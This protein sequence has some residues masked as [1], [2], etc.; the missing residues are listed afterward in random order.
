F[1]LF[2]LYGQ[3]VLRHHVGIL[4]TETL[5]TTRGACKELVNTTHERS[6]QRAGRSRSVAGLCFIVSASKLRKPGVSRCTVRDAPPG[7]S[8][9]SSDVR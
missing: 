6:V 7:Q 4:L 3:I 2:R 9:A 1:V 5:K 8:S